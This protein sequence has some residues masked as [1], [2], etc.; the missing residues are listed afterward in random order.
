A[1]AILRPLRNAGVRIALDDFGMGYAG[2][3]QLQH[4]KSLPVDILKIDKMFVDGLP[5][6][7]S[8][9]TAII[10]MARSLNLQLIAEGVENEAQRAW[11][12]QA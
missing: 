8:M 4:M 1:V 12:E 11:L 5:D 2:L 10:L 7:H 9:V 3:R 6:D